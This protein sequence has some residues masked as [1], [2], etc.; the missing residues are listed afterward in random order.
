MD[1]TSHVEFIGDNPNWGSWA[2]LIVS[3]TKRFGEEIKKIETEI[4]ENT[5]DINE[6][7]RSI[8]KLGQNENIELLKKDILAVDSGQKEIKTLLSKD[9]EAANKDISLL[10]RQR[11]DLKT[12]VEGL[13]EFRTKATTAL[14]VI[15][16]LLGVALT[17]I[18]LIK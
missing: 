2:K 13:K 5:R 6:V 7:Q 11:E 10:K 8:I 16:G 4:K 12:N 14:I 18:S 1:S 9:I 15:N 3:E 17:V